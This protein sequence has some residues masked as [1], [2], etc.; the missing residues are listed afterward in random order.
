MSSSLGVVL[1]KSIGAGYFA[2][3]SAA[4]T[5]NLEVVEFSPLGAQSQILVLGAH[6]K[7]KEFIVELRTA[8][9]IRST[10]VANFNEQILKNYLSLETCNQKKF[11]LILEANFVGDLFQSASELVKLGLSIVDFR[12]FRTTGSPGHVIL[13]GEEVRVATQ[14]ISAQQRENLQIMLIEDLC[15][16]FRQFFDSES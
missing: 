5:E 11:T 16:G 4:A 3:N 14:W 10:I 9:I 2:L 6:Q 13:T 7:V 12:V 1:M 15:E 8:E